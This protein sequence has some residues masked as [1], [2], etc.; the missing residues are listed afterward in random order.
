MKKLLFIS[1]AI[2]ILCTVNVKAQITLE[3]SYSFP[4]LPVVNLQYSGSKYAI[5][6]FA[7]SQIL[8]FNLDHTAYKQINI[9]PQP[10]AT[11]YKIWYLTEGLFNTDSTSVAYL[12]EG[13]VGS[14]GLFDTYYVSIYD[15]N[16]TQLFHADN[17]FTVYSTSNEPAPNATYTPIF[18]TEYGT[19]M[20]LTSSNL[21]MPI[22]VSVYSLP[23][24]LPCAVCDGQIVSGLAAP[25][26]E[27]V[28]IAVAPNPA[29]SMARIDYK[30]PEN[31]R[32]AT[33]VLYDA[34]GKELKR[35]GID[36]RADYFMLPVADLTTGIYFYSLEIPGK[37][38]LAKKMMVIH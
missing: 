15:E 23:G 21:L 33:I 4:R 18:N 7:N 34:Y 27:E 13:R 11:S 32:H 2:F 38:P 19:K 31:V 3:T 28:F 14:S 1:S 22:G 35:Y 26:H 29:N 9:P 6:D 25:V 17:V 5:V 16:G 30:L 8:L 36:V 10:S 37:N 24:K 12:L 20:V